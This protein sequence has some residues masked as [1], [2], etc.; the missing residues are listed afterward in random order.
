[1]KLATKVIANR[2]KLLMDELVSPNQA[3]FVPGRQSLDNYVIC[4]EL[5][6]SLKYTKARSGGMILKV[7]L[8]KAYDMMEWT[9]VEDML[10]DIALPTNVISVL[11]GL[12]RSSSC[13]LLFNGEVT[14]RIKPTRGLR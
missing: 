5:V 6:H 1:M 2:L 14:E 7:D 10:R 8:E 3:S 9:F 4:Q 11:M 13:R 12:L